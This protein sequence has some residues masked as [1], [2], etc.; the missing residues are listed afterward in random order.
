ML[1]DMERLW[2]RQ[3]E[4]KA[5]HKGPVSLRPRCDGGGRPVTAIQS[6]S[7]IPGKD[8]EPIV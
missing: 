6:T 1:L 4:L 2:G 5:V 7:L 3:V 8:T